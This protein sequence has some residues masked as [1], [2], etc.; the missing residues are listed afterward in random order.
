MTLKSRRNFDENITVCCVKAVLMP[1]QPHIAGEIY[2]LRYLDLSTRRH[3]HGLL[4]QHNEGIVI[5][6]AQIF[7]TVFLIGFF[8]SFIQGRG[9]AEYVAWVVYIGFS[10]S[11]SVRPVFAIRKEILRGFTPEELDEA[12]TYARYCE[13]KWFLKTVGGLLAATVFHALLLWI[14]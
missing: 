13:G 8:P 2:E 3:I 10:L 1:D 11:W 14:L 5:L 9:L 12:K 6:T 4:E 7:L